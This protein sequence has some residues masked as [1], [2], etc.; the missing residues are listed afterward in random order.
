M[1]LNLSSIDDAT[2]NWSTGN[3]ATFMIDKCFAF[4]DHFVHVLLQLEGMRYVFDSFDWCLTSRQV[5]AKINC[6]Y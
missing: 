2:V 6:Y 3:I 1:V 4:S 5:D